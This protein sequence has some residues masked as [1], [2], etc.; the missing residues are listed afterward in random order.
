M[1]FYYVAF[2]ALEAAGHTVT[3]TDIPGLYDVEGVGTDLTLGQLVD[4]AQQRGLT[5]LPPINHPVI[6]HTVS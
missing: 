5:W 3:P 2:K 1:M 4:V 6:N